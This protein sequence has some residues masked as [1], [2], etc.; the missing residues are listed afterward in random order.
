[1]EFG[2]QFLW[3]SLFMSLGRSPLFKSFQIAPPRKAVQTGVDFSM[4]VVS[5]LA[6]PPPH[7]GAN[8]FGGAAVK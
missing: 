6:S 2:V 8:G 5:F 3:S 4:C 7:L 1:M